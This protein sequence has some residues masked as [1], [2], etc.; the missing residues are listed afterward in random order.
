MIK[1]LIDNEEVV[2][3]SNLQIKEE[4]LSTSSTILK[5]C[6]PKS[7]EEDKDYTSRYYFPKDYAKCKIID[8][9]SIQYRI[10]GT[11]SQD[12]TPTLNNP[13]PIIT[14]T[15]TITQNINGYN[16]T[17]DL[18]DIQL[19]QA[20]N[21][22]FYTDYIAKATGKNLFNKNTITE[23][24]SLNTDGTL[25]TNEGYATSDYI[26]VSGNTNYVVSYYNYI[27]ADV[28]IRTVFYDANKNFISYI[29]NSLTSLYHIN[30]PTN[31]KYI[32]FDYKIT[33]FENIQVEK[34]T[35]NTIYEPFGTDWYICKLTRIYKVQLEDITLESYTNIDYAKITMPSNTNNGLTAYCTHAQ[36]KNVIDYDDASNV[37]YIIK[38]PGSTINFYIGF[39]K[40]TSL[41]DMKST[42]ENCYIQSTNIY[43][44]IT[45]INSNNY[46]TLYNQ[47]LLP[48]NKLLFCGYVKNTGNISLN[49][50]DPHYV[51]L[52][53]LDFKD[54]L[55]TGETLNYVINNQTIL[56]A[57]NQVVASISDYGFVV[58]NIQINNPDEVIGAYSTLNKTAYDVFQYIADI[59]QSKWT[60]RVIDENTIAI[61]FYDPTLMPEGLGIE[62]TKAFYETNMIDDI[63]F[64]YSTN[65]YRNKQIMTSNEVFANITQ[66]ETLVA[67]GYNKTYICEN[68]VGLITSITVN[69]STATFIT[70]A[71]EEQGQSADFV[72]QPGE[73]T[74]N[75]KN[76]ISSG[77]AIVIT[78]YPLVKGREIILNSIESTRINNQINRKGT[79]S[80]YENRNDT[81]S[82]VELQKIGQSYLLYKGKAEITL[83][84]VSEKDLWNV[85]E[86]VNYDAPL[87]ELNTDYMVKS[88]TI[89]MYLNAHKVFYTY[90][91][92]SNYNYE[93]AVNYFDNQRAK[94]QGNIGEGESITRNIDIENTAL[95]KFYDTDIQEVE[96][97][98]YTSLDFSLDGVII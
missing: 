52:Q 44:K 98:N 94:N 3:D 63:S 62:N 47:L 89:D 37:N 23:D 40:G 56:Q 78:Y 2:S 8:E 12:G 84:I 27:S 55:S 92:T 68:K 97:G 93:N 91:L 20:P 19:C 7:W 22:T 73:N 14:K 85:G 38:E 30:T 41:A 79:I 25:I 36:Q 82:S 33:S 24:K 83:K 29:D 17:F 50:R 90:E 35:V 60:T 46:P 11:S 21:S 1:I 70:K 31:A 48:N 16:Y 71:Q 42:L 51:D 5:N 26:E 64:N 96:V 87:E 86:I 28:S 18:G 43:R 13:I 66:T 69:G 80:R 65:D 9:N 74:I 54:L 10:E 58:G 49:P 32:R 76:T 4:M 53:I 72:Y 67:D 39:P 45:I 34:G 15:G 57:I 6:Y 75:S 61:D 77:A 88:K 81:I 59:T 95:I